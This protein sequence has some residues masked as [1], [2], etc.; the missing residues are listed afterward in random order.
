MNSNGERLFTDCD[1]DQ[2][3]NVCRRMVLPLCS[4]G[5]GGETPIWNRRGYSSEI[6]NLTPKGDH[7]GV[8]QA[9]CDPSR[10]PIWAW[11]KQI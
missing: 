11:V 2:Y 5:G 6:L 1:G 10:R 9:F 7:Q 8:A 4:P 3:S